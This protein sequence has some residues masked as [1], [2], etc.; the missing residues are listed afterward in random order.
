MPV[1]LPLALLLLLLAL[2]FNT[3]PLLDTAWLLLGLYV[4]ARLGTRSASRALTVTRRC[5]E[6]AYTGD[7]LTVDL[8]L[9]NRSRLPIPWLTLTEETPSELREAPPPLR[10]I[11]LGGREERHL[12]YTLQCRHRGY[13]DLGPA[14]VVMGDLLGLGERGEELGEPRHLIV[15]PR[16]VPLE[17][18]GLP[19][20]SAQV[21]LPARTP[22][23]EDPARIS[24]VR[25]YLPTDS[26]RHVHW[27]ASARLGSLVVKRYQPSIAR[28]TVIALDLDLRDYQPTGRSAT[29]ELAI[30]TAAS[31]AN[32]IIMR[33]RQ[34]ASLVAEGR[35]PLDD[36]VHRFS[37]PPGNRP[38]HLV[39]MLEV[40]ARIQT[41][42]GEH[43]AAL[44]REVGVALPW[45]TTL[46]AISGAQSQ[47]LTDTLLYLRRLGL[48][49]ALLLV[50]PA[51][52]SL[53]VPQI[54]TY[55][56]STDADLATVTDGA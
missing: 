15:Y 55:T 43:F 10:A 32:H 18:L 34:S 38:A 14:T 5:V 4:L 12:P 2:W 1:Y 47:V 27:P 53:A 23:F 44:L 56:I 40:L 17:R 36:V 30:V 9:R 16:V 52:M 42:P 54:P 33:E 35:D 20:R 3:A 51:E 26:L 49:V 45:G 24:G 13:Y 25:E 41:V 37:L 29:V 8:V 11:S 6:R 19:T 7:E 46:L 28:S 39:T 50:H 31:L 48:A 22:L 21:A